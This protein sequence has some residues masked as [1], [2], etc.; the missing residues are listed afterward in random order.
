MR[1]REDHLEHNSK[2]QI[3]MKPYTPT[4]DLAR[5]TQECIDVFLQSKLENGKI[6]GIDWWQTANGYTATALH[7]TWSSENRLQNYDNVADAI[8]QCES[9]K[10]GFINEFNDDTLWWALCCLHVYAIRKDPWVLDRAVHIWHHIHDSNSICKQGQAHFQNLDMEGACYWTTNLDEEQVNSIS[11]GLFAELSVRLGLVSDGEVLNAHST[12][13]LLGQKPTSREDYIEAARCSLGWILRCRY[14]DEDAL[15]LDNFLLR[16]QI[17]QDWTF[18]YTTGVTI[19]V[20]ALLLEATQS[21][22]YLALACDMAQ[23]A[24][25]RPSWVEKNGVLTEH[26]A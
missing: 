24:M 10:P 6:R 5:I 1:G 19:G 9:G 4:D 17:A 22:E 14:R 11:T 13:P 8:R 25:V 15:V 26:S 21:T 18:T 2:T 7:D 16:Q 3:T 20:C 12:M 23:K